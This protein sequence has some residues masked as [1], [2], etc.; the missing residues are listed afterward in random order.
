ML[1]G[2]ATT[3]QL[4]VTARPTVEANRMPLVRGLFVSAMELVVRDVLLGW[5]RTADGE[6]GVDESA[7]PETAVTIFRALGN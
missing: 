2:D 4:L 3:G 6:D 1:P 7:A 5:L